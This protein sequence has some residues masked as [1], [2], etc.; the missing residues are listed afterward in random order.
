MGA[1]NKEMEKPHSSRAKKEI[2][3]DQVIVERHNRTLAE[4]LFRHQCA[5]EKACL[6]GRGPCRES[7]RANCALSARRAETGFVRKELLAIP[8]NIIL[9][10]ASCG[11]HPAAPNVSCNTYSAL[12][13][14]GY[15]FA[16]CLSPS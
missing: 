4:R 15:V 8:P 7:Q 9:Q 16:S 3:W 14:F 11:S 6:K 10:W 5:V 2:H 12:A 13:Y 1:V